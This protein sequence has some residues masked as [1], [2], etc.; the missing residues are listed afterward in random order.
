MDQR[1]W[2]VTAQ[3]IFPTHIPMDIDSEGQAQLPSQLKPVSRIPKSYREL[4]G[5]RIFLRESENQQ[6]LDDFRYSVG[7]LIVRLDSSGADP[8]S[9]V[10]VASPIIDRVLESLSFQM[11]SALPIAALGVI[12][13]TGS[14]MVGEERPCAQW[15]GFATPTFRPASIPMESLVGRI[16]P[17][18]DIDLDPE[19]PRANR[20]LDW[21]LKSLTANFETDQFIFLWIACEILAADS[22]LEVRE[23]YRVPKCRHEITACPQCGASTE[24]RVQGP[25]MV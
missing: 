1:T 16:I 17:D 23:P 12:E 11:Q 2:Q 18:I 5:T 8:I 19:D 3:V 24:A 6:F 9:A 4:D 21:Y 14:P 22:G 25:S 15:S 13:L 10:Q 20:A 7:E